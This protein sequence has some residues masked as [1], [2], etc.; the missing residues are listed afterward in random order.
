MAGESGSSLCHSAD[1]KPGLS[2]ERRRL[3]GQ[4]EDRGRTGTKEAQRGGGAGGG[5]AGGGRGGRGAGG[6]G[7]L[8]PRRWAR[9]WAAGQDTRCC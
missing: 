1:L 2:A 6:G 8:L 9:L 5:A 4:R 3:E 7:R